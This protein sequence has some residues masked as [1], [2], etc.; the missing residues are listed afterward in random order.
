MSEALSQQAIA[1]GFAARRSAK[2]FGHQVSAE[3][4]QPLLWSTLEHFESRQALTDFLYQ[5]VQALAPTVPN[6]PARYGK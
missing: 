2:K 6:K 3:I 5:Q 1:E 4:R